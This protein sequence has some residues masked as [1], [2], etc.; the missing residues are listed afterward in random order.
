MIRG[1]QYRCETCLNFVFC[2]K[3]YAHSHLLHPDHP[4]QVIGPEF[5]EPAEESA[6]W[7]DTM[8]GEAPDGDASSQNSDCSSIYQI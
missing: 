5:D 3:C 6:A 2:N 8:G 1:L 7:K 4:F